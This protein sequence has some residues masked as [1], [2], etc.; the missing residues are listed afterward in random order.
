MTEWCGIKVG[1]LY[2]ATWQA[3][4]YPNVLLALSICERDWTGP[5]HGAAREAY[6]T[7]LTDGVYVR[8]NISEDKTSKY[9]R[10]QVKKLVAPA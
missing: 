1:G 2:K 8:W 10:S 5:Q 9:G 6:V 4:R 7:F 3:E